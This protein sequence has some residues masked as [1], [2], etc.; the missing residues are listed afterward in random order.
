MKRES[1]RENKYNELKIKCT[2]TLSVVIW[3]SRESTCVEHNR[4]KLKRKK[5]KLMVCMKVIYVIEV[6]SIYLNCFMYYS[7]YIL[8]DDILYVLLKCWV[9]QMW[10]EK[11]YLY[12]YFYIY[13]YIMFFYSN[14]FFY[15]DYIIFFCAFKCFTLYQI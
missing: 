15:S 8:I 2:L 7:L 10:S 3:D 13:S 5:L 6:F 12:T 11:R 9:T 14:K 4:R 1:K